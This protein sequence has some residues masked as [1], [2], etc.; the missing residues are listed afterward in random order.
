MKAGLKTR[1][2]ENEK[3]RPGFPERAFSRSLIPSV[4][5]IELRRD[6]E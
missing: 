4:S 3:A 2:Y 1:L 5:E 6:L